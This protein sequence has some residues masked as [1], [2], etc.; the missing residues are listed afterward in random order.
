MSSQD[1][2]NKQAELDMSPGDVLTEIQGCLKQL[3]GNSAVGI[4]ETVAQMVAAMVAAMNIRPGQNNNM[5]DNCADLLALPAPAEMAA[6]EMHEDLSARAQG[7]TIGLNHQHCT[8]P[9]ASS[10]QSNLH[11][12]NGAMNPLHCREGQAYQG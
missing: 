8:T 6:P 4:P 10:A 9:V 11:G 3:C 12:H 5:Q 7:C 1:R 2:A